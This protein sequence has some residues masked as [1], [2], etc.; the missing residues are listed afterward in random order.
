MALFPFP[1]PNVSAI[2]DAGGARLGEVLVQVRW[3][4][5]ID[6]VYSGTFEIPAGGIGLDESVYDALKR[7]VLGETGLRVTGFRPDV[8]TRTHSHRGD[9][10]FAFVPF[11]CQQLGGAARI[12]VGSSRSRRSGSSSSRPVL[13]FF[14]TT[15]G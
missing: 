7:E 10:V 11:C 3:K 14:L 15:P 13:E 9:D 6:P 1:V 12:G 8:R 5:G 2:I 4:P